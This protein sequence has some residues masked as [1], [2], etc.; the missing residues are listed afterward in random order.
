[1]KIKILGSGQDGGVPQIGC[2]CD[3]CQK[4]RRFKR[5]RRFAPSI[6]VED[7]MNRSSVIIDASPDLK[8]QWQML[9]TQIVALLL[10]H[11]HYGHYSGLLQFGEEVADIKDLPLWC[12]RRMGR[13]LSGNLPFKSLI[14]RK[15][16][17]I[18]LINPGKEFR[19]IGLTFTAIKVP[20]RTRVSDTVGYILQ[21]SRKKVIYIPDVDY[22]TGGLKRE[23]N[24]ADIALLDGT[25]FSKD[26]IRRQQDVPHPPIRKTVELLRDSTTRIYFTH[27]N[28]SNP[29]NK[30]GRERRYV[31]DKNFKVAHD[32]LEI[33]I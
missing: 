29:V 27:I 22:W 25:F 31:E 17:R 26:E 16:I 32:G 20:H 1:M 3:V 9:D 18:N 6:A 13:F 28:H 30:D 5:Y 19:M 11:A 15:N 10:T 7:E 33:K 23:I 8:Y 21:S 14:S 12:T 24:S 4:A 2:R